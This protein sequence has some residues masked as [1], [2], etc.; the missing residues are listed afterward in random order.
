MKVSGPF[1]DFMRVTAKSLLFKMI[2][3][4]T[5]FYILVFGPTER[6]K[7]C[8]GNIAQNH[9]AV[10]EERTDYTLKKYLNGNETERRLISCKILSKQLTYF[11]KTMYSA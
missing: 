1:I 5:E 11:F 7:R 9:L 8:Q 2:I 10:Q 6:L 4:L 3:M